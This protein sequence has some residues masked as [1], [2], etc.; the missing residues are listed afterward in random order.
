MFESL[1]GNPT[2]EKILFFLLINGDGYPTQ[3]AERFQI[4]LNGIQQQFQRLDDGGV[5]VSERVGKTRVYRF[6]P[7]YPLMS[8]LREFLRHAA[9][10]IEQ[11][12][13]KNYSKK[14]DPM[15]TPYLSVRALIIQNGYLLVASDG[16]GTMYNYLPGGVVDPAIGMEESL[17]NH[18]MDQFNGRINIG[19]CLGVIESAIE[20]GDESGFQ[21]DMVFA[22]ELTNY[23]HP[24]RP[25]KGMDRLFESYWH[26]LA[27]LEQMQLKPDGM[28]D[29]VHK[30]NA[31]NTDGIIVQKA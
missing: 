11:E 5:V 14:D 15:N 23:K 19:Q 8:A 1:F 16:S 20:S 31:D 24:E 18:I 29:L 30:Y 12:E 27:K 9:K 26:P 4:S 17:R 25:K 28:V 3:I 6:N 10:H 13:L 21:N 2:V 22:V 7:R